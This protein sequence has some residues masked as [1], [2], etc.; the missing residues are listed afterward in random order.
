MAEK[1]KIAQVITRMD[2]GGSPDI[3]RLMCA[4]LDPQRY[5]NRLITGPSLHLSLETNKFLDRYRDQTQIVFS[6]KRDILPLDDLRALIE[7]YRIFRREKFDIVHTHTAK[8]GVLG[9]L[10]ARLAGIPHIIHTP[11][12]HNFYGYFGPLGSKLV[13]LIEKWLSLF[14]DKIMTLTELERKDYVTFRVCRPEKITVINSGIELEKFRNIQIDQTQKRAEFS[15]GPEEIV[16]G[17][18]GRLEPVKGPEFLIEA[19]KAVIERIPKIKFLIVG[20]GSLRER[21]EERCYQLRIHDRV[22]FTSWREDIPEILSILDVVVLPSLNEA[23]G[24][25]LIEAG[26]LGKPVVATYV[27]GIPE[28]VKDKETGI[29]VSPKSVTDLAQALIALARDEN[30][31]NQMGQAARR[32]IDD[33][34]SS[35]RMIAQIARLYEELLKERDE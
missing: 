4:Q 29:L 30:R 6:L 18:M 8:A 27:G 17:M 20:E 5:D 19:A 2:W 31:R 3:V 11:H 7:L 33:K 22:I 24:R 25:I 1:I 10:A 9:R 15:I 28:I 13:I 21:L 35:T 26:A 14:T 12:G 34:F 16:I 23:V 32:W